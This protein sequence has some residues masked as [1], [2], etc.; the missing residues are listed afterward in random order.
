MSEVVNSLRRNFLLESSKTCLINAEMHEWRTRATGMYSWKYQL[1]RHEKKK[2]KRNETK[3]L[4]SARQKMRGGGSYLAI[5]ALAEKHID[6][7]DQGN[8]FSESIYVS[9]QLGRR[10]QSGYDLARVHKL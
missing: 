3:I 6:F 8:F 10:L 1:M 5:E 4:L 7:I 9:R 2:E